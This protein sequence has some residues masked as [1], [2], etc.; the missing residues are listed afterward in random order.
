MRRWLMAMVLPALLPMLLMAP[1]RADDGRRDDA[2]ALV[3]VWRLIRYVDTPDGGT[4][5]HAFGPTPIGQ[6]VFTADGHVAISIMRNPP[7]PAAATTDIDPDA[8]LPAWYCSYFGTYRVDADG[9]RW[10]T[11]VEGGNIPAYL[12]TDQPRAFR[13]VGDRLIISED[14]E[15]EGR[16][17][18]AE[19][20][21]VR[22]GRD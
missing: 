19:R 6:F 9:R 12:G 8:C 17:V 10:I 1:V 22:A 2:A 14:Y 16:R 3:G 20:E 4:P 5:V 7:D 21:L 18:H 15:A 13:I 11:H